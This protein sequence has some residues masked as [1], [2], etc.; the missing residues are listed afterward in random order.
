MF[1]DV[2]AIP[3][4][5]FRARLV[6]VL[7]LSRCRAIMVSEALMSTNPFT[8]VDSGSLTIVQIRVSTVSNGLAHFAFVISDDRGCQEGSVVED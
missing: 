8:P 5:D 4:S 7:D 6:Y 2:T 3:S 1:K